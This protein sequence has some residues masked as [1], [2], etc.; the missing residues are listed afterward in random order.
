VRLTGPGSFEH[1][2]RHSSGCISEGERDHDDVVEWSDHG[3]DL[4]DEVDR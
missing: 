3:Q 1:I 2:A 4:G